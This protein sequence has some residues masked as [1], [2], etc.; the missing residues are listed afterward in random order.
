MS[1]AADQLEGSEVHTVGAC[2][3]SVRSFR[4]SVMCIPRLIL[5]EEWVPRSQQIPPLS[6]HN[7][8][9]LGIYNLN[10]NGRTHRANSNMMCPLARRCYSLFPCTSAIASLG[11]SLQRSCL[12]SGRTVCKGWGN[13]VVV[14]VARWTKGIQDMH[15]IGDVSTECAEIMGQGGYAHADGR[16]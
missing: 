9:N 6:L 16:A 10:L 3:S 4:S 12:V 2:E 5:L 8:F 13:Q 1:L 15:D 7:N 14:H 11:I